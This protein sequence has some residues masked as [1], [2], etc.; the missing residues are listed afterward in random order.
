MRRTLIAL[1]LTMTAVLAG[2]TWASPANAATFDQKLA[3]VSSFTQANGASY[4][5]W[6]SA[7]NNQGAYADYALDWSTDY[8]SFSPDQPLGFDFRIPC[9][10]HDFGYRNFK[11]LGRFPGNKD[12]VD[13]AFY[14][15]LKAK[16]ATYSWVVRPAC[17]S[18]A[19][20]Y[21]EAVHN[22]GSLV[23]SKAALDRAAADKE[24]ALN[25]QAATA[26]R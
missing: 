13:D 1:V 26:S 5:A 24:A 11:A 10:R 17:Y 7:R 16:C 6:N 25:R 19:W 23:V 12:H 18:L 20:T 9:W 14:F 21:Y 2:L 8:C 22:F 3:L 15:D 4:S